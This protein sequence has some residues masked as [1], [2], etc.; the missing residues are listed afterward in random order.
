[1]VGNCNFVYGRGALKTYISIPLQFGNCFILSYLGYAGHDR[2][3]IVRFFIH[4]GLDK[5]WAIQQ[6]TLNLLNLQSRDIVVQLSLTSHVCK[7]LQGTKEVAAR[8]SLELPA[9]RILVLNNMEEEK[10]LS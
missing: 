5:N 7:V 6:Q 1:M 9:P 8:S 2:L 3:L 10:D 4:E